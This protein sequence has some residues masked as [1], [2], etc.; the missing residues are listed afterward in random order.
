MLELHE[1]RARVGIKRKKM[2]IKHQIEATDKQ[3]DRLV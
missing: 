1:R 3:I 2:V